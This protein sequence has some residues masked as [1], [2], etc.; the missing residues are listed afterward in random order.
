MDARS[1]VKQPARG[2]A[3]QVIV[4][5]GSAYELLLGLSV[6]SDIEPETSYAVGETWFDEVR[7]KAPK[8]L[9]DDIQ[10]LAVGSE[11]LFGY[12]I[13]LVPSLPEPTV[14]ALL[15][16]VEQLDPIE[17]R[18]WLLGY[19]LV[20]Y[21]EGVPHELIESAARGNKRAAAQL[22]EAYGGERDV[23]AQ[24]ARE[25]EYVLS[26][27]AREMKAL[28]LRVLRGWNEVVF[29]P[30]ADQILP[31]LQRSAESLR[32]LAG[33]VSL[34]RLVELTSPGISYAPE[35]G[36]K[37]LLLV[38]GFASRPWLVMTESDDTK[39]FC[40]GIDDETA[41]GLDAPPDPMVKVYRALS[42]PS[43]LRLMKRLSQGRA[44]LQELVDYLGLAKST[45]HAHVLVLRTSGLIEVRLSDKT[46]TLRREAAEEAHRLL[47]GFLGEEVRD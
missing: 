13:G 45:V 27:P 1:H 43:R 3:V 29:E 16:H 35:P 32:A 47:K 24:R 46:Y 22:K 10:R 9:R 42:D 4:D 11:H 40:Y 33:T 31:L 19:H 30:I 14:A 6:F 28:L 2:G 23:G 18:L 5:W 21:R 34:E 20:A 41:K 17:L 38:P 44:S 25:V 12:L 7:V 39:I 8:A 36:I 37:K 26:I 15:E